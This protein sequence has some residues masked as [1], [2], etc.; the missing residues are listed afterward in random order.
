MIVDPDGWVWIEPV[1]PPDLSPRIE[2]WRTHLNA[3]TLEVDTVEVFPLVFL[4][5]GGYAGI[6]VDSLGSIEPRRVARAPHR[7]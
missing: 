3:L 1:Q 7:D 4:R 6:V 5:D 2:V